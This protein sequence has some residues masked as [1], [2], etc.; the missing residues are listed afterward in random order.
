MLSMGESGLKTG[1]RREIWITHYSSY[2]KI[3][4]VGEGDFSFSACLARA[5][6]S[7]HNMVAT[8]IDSEGRIFNSYSLMLINLCNMILFYFIL[9][10]CMPV[11]NAL[12]LELWSCFLIWCMLVGDL[13]CMHIHSEINCVVDAILIIWPTW[14]ASSAMLPVKHWSSVAHLHELKNLGCTVLHEVDVNNMH[15]HATLKTMKFDRIVFNFPH[16][17]HDPRYGERHAELIRCTLLVP[18][19]YFLSAS[20]Y[21]SNSL[22]EYWPLSCVYWLVHSRVVYKLCMINTQK[23]STVSE[24]YE[25]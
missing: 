16:A 21:I 20:F 11:N 25:H 24:H 9:Q 22:R 19:F 3:L 6:G 12:M 18:F 7:A 14:N 2:H 23:L 5:F 4:L 15:E 17:G 8:S 13:D 10:A 1:F